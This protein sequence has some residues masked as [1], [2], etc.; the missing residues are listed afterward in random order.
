[1]NNKQCIFLVQIRFLKIYRTPD[2]LQFDTQHQQ[3]LAIS[4]HARQ[5][6][7]LYSLFLE[8][9]Q[10]LGNNYIYKNGVVSIL[11]IL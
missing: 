11:C 1:M 3:F 10:L 7:T 8:K 2:N 5:Q 4:D 6:I 9:A